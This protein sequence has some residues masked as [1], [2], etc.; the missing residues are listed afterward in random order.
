[1]GAHSTQP[2]SCI[3][4][5]E[6]GVTSKEGKWKAYAID[7]Q[8]R[9]EAGFQALQMLRLL[10]I[11]NDPFITRLLKFGGLSWEREDHRIWS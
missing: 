4:K 6:G 3:T 7:K 8:T 5:H 9:S 11:L 2:W 10:Q 1:M